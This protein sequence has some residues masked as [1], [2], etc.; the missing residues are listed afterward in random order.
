MQ[1]FSQGFGEARYRRK[2]SAFHRH[3]VYTELRIRRELLSFSL[4]WL[5]DD[6]PLRPVFK[7]MN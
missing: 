1:T 3:E 4:V 5:P 2:E 6:R 7:N